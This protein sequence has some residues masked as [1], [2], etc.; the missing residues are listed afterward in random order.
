[1]I[2]EDYYFSWE[3]DAE[4]DCLYIT[5]SEESVYKTVEIVDGAFMF[6]FDVAGRLRGVEII[7]PDD[8]WF[9]EAKTSAYDWWGYFTDS[10]LL[11]FQRVM[12]ERAWR[13]VE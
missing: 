10:Q 2:D 6:D 4:C 1:M 5:L 11:Y 8:A 13:N 7:G 12:T 3:Y 9:E